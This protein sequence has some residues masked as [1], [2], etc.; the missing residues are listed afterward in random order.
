MTELGDLYHRYLAALNERRLEDL[1]D[2]V[3]DP[4]VS[5]DEEVSLADYKSAISASIEAVPDFHWE[6]EDLVTDGQRL[7]VR[8]ADTGTQMGPWLGIPASGRPMSTRE[9]AFY[10]YHDGRIAQMWF[11]LDIPAIRTQLE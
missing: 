1:G 4:V 3:H 2:F 9:F 10:Q 6:I 7:A 8:L 11:L 5:N